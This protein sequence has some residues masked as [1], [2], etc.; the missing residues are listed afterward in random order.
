MASTPPPSS[1]TTTTPTM[2]MRKLRKSCSLPTCTLL[3]GECMHC[4]CDGKCGRHASGMCGV[5]REGS[6]KSCKRDGCSRDDACFHSTRATCCHCRNLVSSQGRSARNKRLRSGSEH[7]SAVV[8]VS[9]PMVL[10]HELAPSSMAMATATPAVDGALKRQKS[11]PLYS[12]VEVMPNT[13]HLPLPIMP[14][15]VCVLLD[16][17]QA[18]PQ[19]PCQRSLAEYR[20]WSDRRASCNLIVVVEGIQFNLHKHPMLMESGLLHA[21]AREYTG[22]HQCA[23]PMLS[24]PSFPGGADVFELLC[25]Y[26]Y[27]GEPVFPTAQ[28]PALYCAINYLKM[29]NDVKDKAE[30]FLQGMLRSA[31]PTTVLQ[32]LEQ[33]TRWFAQ[34]P[35]AQGDAFVYACLNKLARELPFTLAS[36]HVLLTLPMGLFLRVTDY[37]LTARSGTQVVNQLRVQ[38]DL[39]QLHQD[40]S[41]DMATKAHDCLSVL[42]HALSGIESQPA[43]PSMEDMMMMIKPEA[44]PCDGEFSPEL[45]MVDGSMAVLPFVPPQPFAV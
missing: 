34:F 29:G 44:S 41:R 5:R 39:G 17:H 24:L 30:Q 2:T 18:A 16:E 28:F 7:V 27:T 20:E 40:N 12:D 43:A 31:H 32:Q 6:G 21:R 9:T 3:P 33:A 15:D 25:I 11:L 23:V 1:A 10:A 14:E 8:P 37:V 42:Q 19:P 36:M 35:I 45:L 4:T 22:L 26:A 13:S 38:A